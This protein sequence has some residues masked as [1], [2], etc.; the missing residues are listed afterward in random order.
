M[1]VSQISIFVPNKA[2]WLSSVSR[3]LGENGVNI[4]ALSIADTTDFGI[5]RLIV[6]DP[7]KAHSLLREAGMT[8]TST[9]VVAVAVDDRPGGLAGA[10]LALEGQGIGIEYLYGFVQKEGDRALVV[11]RVENVPAAETALSGAGVRVLTGDEIY[12]L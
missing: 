7:A 8:V 12:R 6:S 11:L 10:L 2:G 3:L 1:P 5:L 9:E 4:R